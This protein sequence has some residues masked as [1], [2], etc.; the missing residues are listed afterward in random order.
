MNPSK[1]YSKPCIPVDRADEYATLMGKSPSVSAGLPTST[2]FRGS[3]GRISNI[4]TVLEPA[5]TVNRY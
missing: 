4:D 2:G 5:F 1:S 3:H